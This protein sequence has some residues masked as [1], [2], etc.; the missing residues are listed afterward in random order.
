SECRAE[1]ELPPEAC[2]VGPWIGVLRELGTTHQN[3]EI[4]PG[5]ECSLP[6]PVL[7]SNPDSRVAQELQL[8]AAAKHPIPD[9]MTRVT[10]Q[11]DSP[12]AEQLPLR[13]GVESSLQ[14]GV[15]RHRAGRGK[16]GIETTEARAARLG[17]VDIRPDQQCPGRP[18]E[19]IAELFERIGT[20]EI[21][22]PLFD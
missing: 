16:P 9:G 17:I 14:L 8:V 6:D 18:E 22:L 19:W 7:G 13:V 2:L 21:D 15:D 11:R 20:R 3:R 10:E 1:T 5:S 4:G 12:S